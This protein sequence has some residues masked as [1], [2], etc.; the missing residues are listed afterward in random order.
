MSTNSLC[1]GSIGHFYLSF[2]VEGVLGILNFGLSY[3]PDFFPQCSF[4]PLAFGLSRV[5][6][7]R[8]K[9]LCDKHH[10]TI[11]ANFGFARALKTCLPAIAS[12]VLMIERLAICP[13]PTQA[14]PILPTFAELKMP[15]THDNCSMPKRQRRHC[16]TLVPV[17]NLKKDQLESLRDTLNEAQSMHTHT[18]FKTSAHTSRQARAPSNMYPTV[19]CCNFFSVAKTL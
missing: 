6:P 10:S 15:F 2:P 17:S 12:V 18:H 8:S 5:A 3:L 19:S 1:W 16:N 4:H 13:Q 7:N 14:K 11:L 9:Y